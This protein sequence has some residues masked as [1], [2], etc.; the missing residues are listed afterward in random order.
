MT[1][2]GRW[3]M[4]LVIALSAGGCAGGDG[5]PRLVGQTLYNSGKYV[6]TQSSN[7]ESGGDSPGGAPNRR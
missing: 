4:L 3:V 2:F 5:W 1:N 7:C 6:C